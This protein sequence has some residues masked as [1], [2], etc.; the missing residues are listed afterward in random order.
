MGTNTVT[1]RLSDAVTARYH[2]GAYVDLID[3]ATGAAFDCMNVWDY[4]ADRATIA[5]TAAAIRALWAELEGD[6]SRRDPA[7]YR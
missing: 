4:A 7:R 5:P 3:A 6:D 1:V 2:G